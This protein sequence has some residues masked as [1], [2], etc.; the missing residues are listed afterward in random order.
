MLPCLR[1]TVYLTDAASVLNNFISG[2]FL[3]SFVEKGL[4]DSE[5]DQ[6]QSEMGEGTS[7]SRPG[8]WDCK[9]DC[10]L[11]S[12]LTSVTSRLRRFAAFLRACVSFGFGLSVRQ[13][14][15]LVYGILAAF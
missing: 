10:R 3:C 14:K 5:R 15:R 8:K 13:N 11:V 2:C 1:R 9:R 6:G 12:P 7:L 4:R